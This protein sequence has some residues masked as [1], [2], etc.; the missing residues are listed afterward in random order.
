MPVM[1]SASSLM[2]DDSY[3]IAPIVLTSGVTHDV[4]DVTAKSKVTRFAS[5]SN[6]AKLSGY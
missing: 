3:L 4:C 5:N 6:L 2:G 1:G